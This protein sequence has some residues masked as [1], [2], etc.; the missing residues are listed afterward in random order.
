V[1]YDILAFSRPNQLLT[2]LGYPWV[3]RTQ[4][5]FGR[6]SA[7]VMFRLTAE[8]GQEAHQTDHDEDN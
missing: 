3:R 7:A 6:E 5:R 1:W 4:K 8:L 2:R